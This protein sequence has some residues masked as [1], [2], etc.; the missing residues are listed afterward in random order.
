[1]LYCPLI[2]VP[3]YQQIKQC[4]GIGMSTVHECLHSQIVSTDPNKNDDNA[5]Y[6]PVVVME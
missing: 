6:N 5:M 1:M 4:W 3:L 2:W